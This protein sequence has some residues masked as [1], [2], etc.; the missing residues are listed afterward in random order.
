MAT[1]I[2]RLTFL[3]DWRSLN[4]PCRSSTP[5]LNMPAK[6]DLPDVTNRSK[7]LK[8]VLAKEEL[9]DDVDFEAIAHMTNGFSGSDLKFFT[10]LPFLSTPTLAA[11]ST[12]LFWWDLSIES[13]V[14]IALIAIMICLP[15]VIASLKRHI[16]TGAVRRR[17]PTLVVI[18]KV[19]DLAQPMSILLLCIQ[20]YRLAQ[21]VQQHFQSCGIVNR[22]R[23]GCKL[24]LIYEGDMVLFTV[25]LYRGRV[26]T[27]RFYPKKET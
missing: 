12:P 24:L 18:A 25:L 14:L 2:V 19:E 5:V 21:E 15:E 11:L 17:D 20:G 23:I 6:I 8:V 26:G 9:S 27:I 7:I 4:M 22:V 16:G 3:A 10:S 13:A 1:S